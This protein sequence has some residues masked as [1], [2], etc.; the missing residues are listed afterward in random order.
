[1]FITKH[2]ERKESMDVM[3]SSRVG[4]RLSRGTYP[5]PVFSDADPDPVNLCPALGKARD[6]SWHT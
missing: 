2:I 4:I 5:Y 1:M 3:L 6:P